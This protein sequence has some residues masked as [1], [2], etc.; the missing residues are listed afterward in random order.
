MAKHVDELTVGIVTKV[1]THIGY[2]VINSEGS[3]YNGKVYPT[4]ALANRISNLYG[5]G[6]YTVKPVYIEESPK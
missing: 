2:V 4:F 5:K 1:M 3:C 6:D